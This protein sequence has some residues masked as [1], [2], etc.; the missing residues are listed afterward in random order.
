MNREAKSTKLLS[1]KTLVCSLRCIHTYTYVRAILCTAAAGPSHSVLSVEAPS[2]KTGQQFL[3][4]MV[5]NFVAKLH[6]FVQKHTH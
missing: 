1:H 3:Q 4:E 2:F 5:Q 6:N